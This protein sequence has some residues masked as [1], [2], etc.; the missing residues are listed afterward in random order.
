M[1]TAAKPSQSLAPPGPF[2][3]VTVTWLPPCTDVGLTVRLGW[4]SESVR[5]AEVPPPGAGENT[6]MESPLAVVARSEAGTTA[7]SVVSFT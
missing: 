4:T 7:V 5:A 1:P 6:V 2:V 3:S